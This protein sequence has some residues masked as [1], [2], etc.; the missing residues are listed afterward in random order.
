M[1][2]SDARVCRVCGRYLMDHSLGELRVCD[3]TASKRG[4]YERA[5]MEARLAQV[6]R[7]GEGDVDRREV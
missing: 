4:D 6:G 7:R 3:G 2:V 5:E 1:R